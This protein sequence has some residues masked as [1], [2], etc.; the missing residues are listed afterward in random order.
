MQQVVFRS[1]RLWPGA[2]TVR[3]RVLGTKS[4]A[5]Q[6][7]W[8]FVDALRAFTTVK[9][10]IAPKCADCHPDRTAAHGG[11]TASH[12]IH[13][14]PDDPRGPGGLECSE[15]HDTSAY[16]SFASGTD[17]DTSGRIE[18]N[19]TDV[20]DGC[21]SPGGAYDGMDSTG[22][23]VGAR[24][25]WATGVYETTAT[26]QA[27]KER[28]CA[29]CH[30]DSP[31]AMR[32]ASA[33]NKLGDD[34]TYGF[35]VTGHGRETTY[36]AMSW[37]GAAAIGNPAA[38]RECVDC[39]A[40]DVSHIDTATADPRLLLGMENDQ[41]DSN[42]GTCHDP[43]ASANNGPT[44]YGTHS[45]YDSSAHADRLC[46][47]CHDPH[48]M[49]G[50][51][52]AMLTATREA[53]CANCHG[54]HDGHAVGVE[55]GAAGDTYT[56][57]CVSCHNVHV[58]SGMYSETT[59][60]VSPVT[61]FSDNTRIWGD[62]L[63]EKMDAAAGSGTYRTPKSEVLTGTQLP[64]YPTFCLD[65]HGISQGTFGPH[66]GISWGTDDPHG[67]N[68]ANVPDGGGIVPD[69]YTAGKAEGWD[70]DARVGTD[71]QCWPVL[72][73]GRGEQI[74]SRGPYEQ[75]ERIAGANF[76]LSCSDCHVT[77]EA[78]IGQKLKGTVNGG[79][80]STSHNTM[81]NN[82]HYYYSD[83]HA[84]MSC[85]NAGCH[86][87]G[88][89]NPRFDNTNTI[90]GMDRRIGSG[91]TRTFDQD[92]V[93]W[94]RFENNLNDSGDWRLHGTWRNGSGSYVSGRSGNGNAIEVSDN[95]LEVGTRDS[96]WST[97][98][99]KHGTWKYS[100]MKYNMTLEAW[101]Y[102][103]TD[104]ASDTSS[105]RKI[106]A[107][108][109]YW[110]G[111]YA[112]VLKN[113]GD[114]WRAALLTNVDPGAKGTWDAD[115]NGLRGAFSNVEIP[116]DEWTHVAV[117]YDAAGP[118]RDS[119]DGS[120][121]RVR[122]WVNGEDVTD[123]YPS[124]S[125]CF[126]QPGPGETAM[127]P[128]SDHNADPV[129]ECYLD[130]WCASAL[131]LGGLNWSTPDDN[132]IGRL[133][134]VKVWNVTKP[135]PYFTPID[136]LVAPKIVRARAEGTKL[137][138]RFSEDTY[139]SAGATG[140][141]EPGDFDLVDTGGNNPKSILAVDHS[142][143]ETTATITV[144]SPFV[145]ADLGADT[146]AA[147]A[148][149]IFDGGGTAA[150][151]GIVV[152]EAVPCPSGTVSIQL[153]ETAG[154]A[155]VSD[156][157]GLITGSVTSTSSP[158]AMGGGYLTGNGAD[159]HIEFTD[160]DECLQA[161][162]NMTIETRIKPSNIP[163]DTTTSYIR[164][165]IDRS[166][167]GNFQVSVWRNP[168]WAEYNPPAG[169]ASIALWTKPVD[170]HG[171]NAWKIALTDYDA[172][173]IVSDHWYQVRV[174][175]DSSKVGTFPV[176]IFVDDQGTDGAGT[177]EQW[178]GYVNATDADQ[179]QVRTVSQLYEGDEITA[180]AGDFTIGCNANNHANNVFDG[181]ID[182][183]TWTG[184]VV[185]TPF[186]ADPSSDKPVSDV[187]KHPTLGLADSSI[188][189]GFEM[190][191]YAERGPVG[192]ESTAIIS[193]AGVSPSAT[194][195]PSEVDVGENSSQEAAY[196]AAVLQTMSP[197]RPAPSRP[198]RVPSEKFPAATIVFVGLAMLLRSAV[199]FGKM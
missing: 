97:D 142:P 37:Q 45:A 13:T 110:T 133:D 18:L 10:S 48:G 111:G 15:C 91:A 31:A 98:D 193:A 27:G 54:A 28:W 197:A 80:G 141:L 118:D 152:I 65:C 73:R 5:S 59:T 140:T 109:T 156:D 75:E 143:G 6:G 136:A 123:S 70:G 16:P 50:S 188:A 39:H 78:G 20:C 82:C 9:D 94:Y 116:V 4:A 144:D 46:T 126:T 71:E 30:D 169:A 93:A 35:F 183:I 119:S 115:C 83:W 69:R 145:S 132:F 2:H 74:W 36:T 189:S 161:E 122:V 165:V 84:G 176:D 107:K 103:T 7:T 167:G 187:S 151:T 43:G 113:I 131:S 148:N 63:S 196:E 38:S 81:C 61:L 195:D 172:Y 182:W 125:Q 181:Q 49:A 117:T 135:A 21:H 89:N 168:S 60:S 164:R 137:Y 76:V 40:A 127:W 184:D 100:E 138:V 1:P 194:E 58:L 108:H 180:I 178:S 72:P 121:G 130:N 23:S 99:G 163:A 96:Y 139:G 105:E 150:G 90:H 56:L 55:F 149:S 160:N 155:T 177:G 179:S 159:N 47:D 106:M 3:I 26:L 44:F 12:P 8:V 92:L 154:A 19:E 128:Y 24:T 192:G 52:P 67:A 42:C 64:N 88:G 79:P 186:S 175:W 66:G 162:R 17:A 185:V 51:D 190:E 199:T 32:G 104:A 147:A 166:I 198:P 153:N 174:E 68:S 25:N 120:V 171:T 11:T 22:G 57:Q 173:P 170:D 101:V 102:P 134:E 124:D 62:D 129:G 95:P 112:F 146:I 191:A 157:S 34:S 158:Q 85:G 114:T 53:L 41:A 87:A 33:P 14:N 77:H 86:G 29:G